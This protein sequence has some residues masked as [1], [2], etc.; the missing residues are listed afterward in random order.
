[1]TDRKPITLVRAAYSPQ[2]EK[3]IEAALR[4]RY[5]FRPFGEASTTYCSHRHS[6]DPYIILLNRHSP[7]ISERRLGGRNIVVNVTTLDRAQGEI[8]I[9]EIS[10]I[11]GSPFENGLSSSLVSLME[12]GMRDAFPRFVE[13]P[14]GFAQAYGLNN[15]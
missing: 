3:A 2:P 8:L 13:D 12:A 9:D 5:T 10:Q 1:M 14:T 11:I 4:S 7:E 15:I 6:P